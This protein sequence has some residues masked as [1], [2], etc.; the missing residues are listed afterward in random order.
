MKRA[1]LHA[2][3]HGHVQGV[4]F[5]AYVVEKATGLNLTG[6][7]RNLPSKVDVEVLAEGETENLEK[8]IPYLRTGPPAAK[9]EDVK[10]T[11]SKYTGKYTGF[12]I[13]Y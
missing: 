3:V 11:W 4:F 12:N 1:S 5:R 9:V 7:V 10:I 8:L 2:L 6:Y 13:R